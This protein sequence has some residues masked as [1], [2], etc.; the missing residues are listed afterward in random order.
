MHTEG[1]RIFHLLNKKW[2]SFGYNMQW[3]FYGIYPKTPRTPP[4]PHMWKV[5]YD[6]KSVQPKYIFL[7]KFFVYFWWQIKDLFGSWGC[8]KINILWKCIGI[9]IRVFYIIF[10][11]LSNL[12]WY[13]L[14]IKTNHFVTIITALLLSAFGICCYQPICIIYY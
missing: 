12:G 8:V 11:S 3:V 14:F 7:G 10:R 2:Y 9:H 1:T 4:Q 5:I 6:V 13:L